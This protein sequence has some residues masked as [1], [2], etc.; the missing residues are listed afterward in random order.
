M[1]PPVAASDRT[2]CLVVINTASVDTYSHFLS[3]IRGCYLKRFIRML[4]LNNLILT[5]TLKAIREL[6]LSYVRKGA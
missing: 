6:S 1:T 3:F 4:L 2:L 5:V